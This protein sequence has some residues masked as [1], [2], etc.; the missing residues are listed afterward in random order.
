[1]A[2]EVDAL[3]AAAV[4]TQASVE[5]GIAVVLSAPATDSLRAQAV[6]V[7]GLVAGPIE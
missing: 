7:A 6:T 1:L 5:S 2:D 3:I 4:D